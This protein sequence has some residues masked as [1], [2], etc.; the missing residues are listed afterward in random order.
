MGP[1]GAGKGTISSMCEAE[2][3]WASLST[4]NLCRKHINEGTDIGKTID[5]IIKSGKLVS[6][7]LI[8]GVVE[9]ELSLAFNDSDTV[10]LDGFP[11]TKAQVSLLVDL[12][13][14]LQFNINVKAAF[15]DV[16][17]DV[18]LN[19]LLGRL[20]CSNKDCQ[21]VYS[22]NCQKLSPK[23]ISKCD[24]CLHDLT[25]RGDDVQEVI[26]NRLR[27]YDKQKNTLLSAYKNYDLDIIKLNADKNVQDVFVNFKDI[28]VQ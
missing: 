10:I 3:N 11:R 27:E 5:F 8:A 26:E 23:D 2:F 14:K 24:K 22:L 16:S 17:N 15:F 6:D 25:K 7:E 18:V 28:V 4:G 13:E 19:R 12:V 9:K 20:T 21:A 1:P